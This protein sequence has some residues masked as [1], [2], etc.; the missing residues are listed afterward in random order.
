MA[1]I[2]QVVE[3]GR[4]TSD[5]ELKQVGEKSVIK[6]SI[7]V[8]GFKENEVSYFNIEYWA[9]SSKVGQ[10]LKKGTQIGILGRLQQDRWE[11]KEGK[12]RS[13]VKIIA[14]QV[15]LLGSKNTKTEE[16]PDVNSIPF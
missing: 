12:K 4:L 16:G 2:N 1:D 8:N 10:Y 15:Q 6:M 11:D 5:A 7:A 9:K 14:Q 13:A 3:V